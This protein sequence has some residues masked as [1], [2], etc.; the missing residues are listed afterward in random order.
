MKNKRKYCIIKLGKKVVKINFKIRYFK[1]N[2]TVSKDLEVLNVINII[3]NI[4]N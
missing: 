4:I 1:N 2:L 3:I